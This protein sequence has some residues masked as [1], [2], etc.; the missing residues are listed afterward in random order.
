MAVGTNFARQSGLSGRAREVL[1]LERFQMARQQ[2]RWFL[3]TAGRWRII[4]GR[5]GLQRCIRRLSDS[6]ISSRQSYNT[7]RDSR[8]QSMPYSSLLREKT[9]PGTIMLPRPTELYFITRS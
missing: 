4:C 5:R 3:F 8:P 1:Q 6:R 2:N 7:R 9:G